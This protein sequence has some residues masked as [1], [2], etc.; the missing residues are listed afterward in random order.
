MAAVQP[1][2]LQPMKSAIPRPESK[3]PKKDKVA[4]FGLRTLDFETWDSSY[5]LDCQVQ[6]AAN[7]VAR[8]LTLAE[9]TDREL[10]FTTTVDYTIGH[11][12]LR[13]VQLRLR[14][15]EEEKVD[16]LAEHVKLW[17]GPRRS[18]G[19]RSWLLPL[20]PGVTKHYQVT[21]RGRMPLD[22]SA[23]GV[24]MPEV[25]V[26]G[27]ERPEYYLA[28]A[29]GELTGQARGS[30]QSLQSPA[31]KLQPF[32]PG[33][34]Q[35]LER[36]GGQAWRVRGSEWQLQLRPHMRTLEPEPVHVFLLEQSSAVVDGRALDARGPLL[37]AP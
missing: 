13:H 6:A 26:Q 27:V 16:V 29:G 33:A 3:S 1:R 11:G 37:A 35:R 23:V 2:N 14:N 9:I 31:T 20:E 24:P 15:W 22:K 5:H 25:I 4:D 12:E 28:V 21:L 19:E 18:S 32:W 7:A 17:P 10:R 34:A 30:L 8:V 36:T